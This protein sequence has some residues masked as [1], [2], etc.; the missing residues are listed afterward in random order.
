MGIKREKKSLGY[1]QQSVEGEAVVQAKDTDINSAL[2]GKIAG[3][4]LIGAPSSSF[5]NALIVYVVKPEYCML[6][7]G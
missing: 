2:A 3:V 7:M 5:D 4:Q 1:S 6:L